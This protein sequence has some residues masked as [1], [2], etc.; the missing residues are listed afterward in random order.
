MNTYPHETDD[1]VQLHHGPVQE[2]LDEYGE[3]GRMRSHVVQAAVPPH[4]LLYLS[5]VPVR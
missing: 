1:L 2:V 4:E 3:H 5:G